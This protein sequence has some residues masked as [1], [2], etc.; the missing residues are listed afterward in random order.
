MI[1]VDMSLSRC[2]IKANEL[3][4]KTLLILSAN[5]VSPGDDRNLFDVNMLSL[6]LSAAV[7]TTACILVLCQFSDRFGLLDRPDNVRKTHIG[8]IPVIG[9]LAIFTCLVIFNLI[10]ASFPSPVIFSILLVVVVGMVDDRFNLPAV[11]KLGVQFLAAAIMIQ[12]GHTEI[13]SLGTL[14]GGDELL[15][16][17]LSFPFSLICI[18]GLVNAMNMID[19]L[20]GLAAGLS[21][22]TLIFLLFVGNFFSIPID[23]HLLAIKCILAGCLG[24]FLCFNLNAIQKYKIFLGD[25]GSMMVGL[26]LSFLLIQI[27]QPRPL[28]DALP[29]SIMPW[30]VAVPIFDALAVVLFRLVKG[31]KPMQADRTHLH[32]CLIDF[33]FSDRQT[34]LIIL[35]LSVVLFTIGMFLLQLG[36]V[37]AGIG[38][39]C[40]AIIYAVAKNKFLINHITS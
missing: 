3:I 10:S 29:A 27:S 34:L 12:T 24:A 30:V 2:H 32:H 15:L 13:L 22:M 33:G 20:D 28:S 11:A 19:G 5:N 36:G 1:H 35:G 4:Q 39:F 38:F 26:I 23:G 9:G 17:D 18:V 14:P 40:F 6:F 21:F 16:Y 8:D 31:Q 7:L 25:A 37:H